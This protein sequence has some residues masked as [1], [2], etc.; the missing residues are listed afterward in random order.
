TIL[1]ST[2]RGR[3]LLVVEWDISWDVNHP[4]NTYETGNH[5][6]VLGTCTGEHP[7]D[8]SLSLAQKPSWI[9]GIA[10]ESSVCYRIGVQNRRCGSR[11]RE[12]TPTVRW[13][14]I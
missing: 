2:T 5:Y 6:L 13:R 10:V 14:P 4:P 8:R 12:R 11:P 9:S 1:S 3:I 7:W